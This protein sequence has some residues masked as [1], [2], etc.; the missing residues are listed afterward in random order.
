MISTLPN[1]SSLSI[2]DELWEYLLVLHPDPL[3]CSQIREEKDQFEKRFEHNAFA[4]AQPRI[5][6]ANFLAKEA[7]EGT[8]NRWI[9][10][11]CK[12]QAPFDVHI[13][14]YSSIPPHTI[15][16]RIQDPAPFQQLANQLQIIDSFIQSNDCPPLILI[17]RPFLA[18][19]QRLPEPI[20]QEAIKE[21]A[22]K[23][24]TAS[25]RADKLTLLKRQHESAPC[26]LVDSFGLTS[27]YAN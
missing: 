3:V 17:S 6:L 14:N 4:S 11:I 27:T 2:D 18:L 15:Y 9:F 16:L 10:N 26:Q 22:Q 8:L 1:L 5:T 13:N 21:Y 19:A 7:M 12:L 25:F 24:F 20:Y 23:H